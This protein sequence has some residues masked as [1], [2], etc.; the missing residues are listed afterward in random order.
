MAVFITRHPLFWVPICHRSLK[1][2]KGGL[3]HVHVIGVF[4]GSAVYF[5]D[6]K[7]ESLITALLILFG[8]LIE[9]S[10]YIYK[11]LF[12]LYMNVQVVVQFY[13]W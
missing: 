10:L 9:D 2:P 5:T 7:F 6:N 3:L 1:L 13:P 12:T 11:Y 8:S 4:I